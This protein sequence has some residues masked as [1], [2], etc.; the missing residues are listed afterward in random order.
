VLELPV[1]NQFTRAH[2]PNGT[3][4]F[5]LKKPTRFC[6]AADKNGGGVITPTSHVLCYQAVGVQDE[7]KHRPVKGLFFSNQFGRELANTTTEKDVCVLSQI[8]IPTP[9]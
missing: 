2:I 9:E 7:P 5:K 4:S 8:Q 6:L 3:K 1:S